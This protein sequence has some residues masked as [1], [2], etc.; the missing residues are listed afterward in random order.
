MFLFTFYVTSFFEKHFISDILSCSRIST[1][2]DIAKHFLP[3]LCTL[4][5]NS[6]QLDWS[7]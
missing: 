4:K 3:T 1:T 6:V 2:F 5:R 7:V